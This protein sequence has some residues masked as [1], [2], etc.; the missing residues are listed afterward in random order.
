M[1]N[2]FTVPPTALRAG[3]RSR[4]GRE[5]VCVF[6]SERRTLGWSIMRAS[7][8]IAAHNEGHSLARTIESCLATMGSLDAE[9]IVADDASNDGSAEEVRRQF[10]SV[11][12]TSHP[13]R[14]GAS[15][16]KDTGARAATGDVLVF[17]DGH[18][19]PEFSSLARM[20]ETVERA[21]GNVIVT[22][23]ILDLDIEAWLS[24]Y[25]VSG[26]GYALDLLTLDTGWLGLEA[27]RPSSVADR[28]LY[29][30]P[31]LI[32][33][34]F[35]ISGRLYR[36]L[37]GFDRHMRSWGVE[38][39]DL[40]LKCWLMGYEILHDP[41]ASVGHHFRESFDNYDVP[42][43]HLLAN[44]IRMARK[45][46]TESVWLQWI[47]AAAAR[48]AYSQTTAAEGAWAA[49][50]LLFH[51]T[52][53]SAEQERAWLQSRRHHDELWFAHTNHLNWPVLVG[54]HAP[55]TAGIPLASPRPSVRPSPSPGIARLVLQDPPVGKTFIID[56]DAQEPHITAQAHIAGVTPDPTA[57]TTFTWTIAITF[58]AAICNHGPARHIN[59]PV[60]TQTTVGGHLDATLPLVRG[61]SLLI[62][63]KAVVEGQTLSAQS[64]SLRIVGTNPAL[65]T[66]H[67]TLPHDTL[68]RI[69]RRESGVRQFDTAAAGSTSA[70]PLWSSDNAGG[71]GVMQLTS[72]APT[73]DQVWS[74]RSNVAGGVALF[75]QRG[76]TARQYPGRVRASA[77][78][79][80]LVT[81]YN[82]HRATQ[83]LPLV[84]VTLPDFTSSGFNVPNAQIG[85]V[86]LDNVRGYNGWAGRDTF[87]FP[88]HEFRVSVDT[89]GLLVVNIQ[90][91]TN[92][93]TAVWERVPAASRPQGVGDPNYVNNVLGQPTF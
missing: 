36:E 85:Q 34:A 41:E 25:S 22:P 68:R 65:A 80:Q 4:E 29:R 28:T 2:Q 5:H 31:A 35:A 57:H 8:V 46:F 43:E 37:W 77:G 74:W 73:D 92:Q 51:E 55:A 45:N 81:A 24:D 69:A 13:S 88:L 54:H 58:N 27:L 63:V 86:E 67:P 50:W 93:G 33:C 44:Q 56:G 78:F 6:G 48:N 76:V 42:M 20:V 71:V 12:M 47:E 15:A 40:G 90:P 21:S 9:I 49:A 14:M 91:G 62:T 84:Q 59:P 53:A 79:A 66:V 19:K 23:S 64:Q 26:H 83:G 87:G 39:I 52:R 1:L 70:C 72:P 75:N 3:M 16:T 38:D 61:G 17:L 18:T 32:G 30:S 10:P 60:V 82:A 89:Q 7:I 11:R